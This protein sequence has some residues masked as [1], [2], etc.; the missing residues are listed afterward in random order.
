[1]SLFADGLIR[2]IGNIKDFN[3]KR[4]GQ[5]NKFKK[6]AQVQNQFIKNL[7]H[8]YTLANIFQREINGVGKTGQLGAK[9]R[10]C[11]LILHDTQK[12]T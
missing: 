6:F 12:S 11:I 2:Y 7:F 9:E 4:W 8:F 10:T 5:I 3:P 1:M